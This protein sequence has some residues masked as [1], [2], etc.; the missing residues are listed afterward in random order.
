MST[1]LADILIE[2]EAN[3]LSSDQFVDDLGIY[4]DENDMKDRAK[5]AEYALA[6]VRVHSPAVYKIG[7]LLFH[8]HELMRKGDAI[9]IAS[10]VNAPHL[11]ITKEIAVWIYDKLF[12]SAPQ[13]GDERIIVSSD[14]IYDKPSGKLIEISKAAGSFVTQNDK[15]TKRIL[16]KRECLRK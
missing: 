3:G 12:S 8:E 14:Y 9:Q 4:F 1:N 6:R 13:L 7:D 15:E 2:R 11:R 5:L 10:L 16:E